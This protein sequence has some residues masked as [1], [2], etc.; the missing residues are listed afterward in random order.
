MSRSL[1]ALGSSSPLR[2]AFPKVAL[3]LSAVVLLAVGLEDLRDLLFE[4]GQALVAVGGLGAEG[5]RQQDQGKGGDEGL[6]G[7]LRREQEGEW[8]GRAGVQ[9]RGAPGR[10]GE[11]EKDWKSRAT[12]RHTGNQPGMANSVIPGRGP[13]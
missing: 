3:A 5:G 2:S 4:V 10:A 11:T 7:F 13:V 1:G 8:R 9:V 6:H 12:S